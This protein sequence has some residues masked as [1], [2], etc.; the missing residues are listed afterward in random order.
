MAAAAPQDPRGAF[1]I[2][3]GEIASLQ[4]MRENKKK[5]INSSKLSHK[6]FNYTPDKASAPRVFITVISLSF[7]SSLVLIKV[8]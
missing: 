5:V 8:S 1:T 6:V 7:P 4:T 3:A 2:C